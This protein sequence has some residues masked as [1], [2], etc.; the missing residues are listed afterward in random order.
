MADYQT[1]LLAV[2]TSGCAVP[3]RYR[4]ARRVFRYSEKIVPAISGSGLI[5]LDDHKKGRSGDSLYSKPGPRHHDS[6][7][8]RQ[9]RSPRS[10]RPASGTPRDQ[11]QQR[12]RLANT[13]RRRGLLTNPDGRSEYIVGPA[14]WRLFRNHDWSMLV[15]FCRHHLK[16]L[17]NLTGESSARPMY[18]RKGTRP[19]LRPGNP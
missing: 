14:I 1:V 6:R 19:Q 10:H 5:D 2:K 11:P 15:S 13:L 8:R 4:G 3:D 12:F 17:S 9:I 18:G 7:S 16:E